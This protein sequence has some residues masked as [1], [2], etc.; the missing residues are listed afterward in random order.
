MRKLLYGLTLLALLIVIP[1]ATAQEISNVPSDLA[2]N[3]YYTVEDS[4]HFTLDDVITEYGCPVGIR[5]FNRALSLNAD[6][7][8]VAG[9]NLIIPSDS[10]LCAIDYAGT[11]EFITVYQAERER[12]GTNAYNLYIPLSEFAAEKNVCEAAI[13][14]LNPEWV[15]IWE[16]YNVGEGFYVDQATPSALPSYIRVPVDSPA[17]FETVEL[18]ATQRPRD[19]AV[20]LN[21]CEQVIWYFNTESIYAP[22][23][24][25]RSIYIPLD[26]QPCY[27]DGQILEYLG[28]PNQW[29]NYIP[30]EAVVLEKA[31][32]VYDFAIENGYCA[33]DLAGLNRHERFEPLQ[34]G[35]VVYVTEGVR[36]CEFVQELSVTT[37]TLAQ[38][39]NVCI[40]SLIAL[41]G[42][43]TSW[44]YVADTRVNLGSGSANPDAF[45]GGIFVPTEEAACYDE[46]GLRLG[47]NDRT[48]H[49]TSKDE[50]LFGIAQ[51]YGVCT[52]DLVK[53]NPLLANYPQSKL[54]SR[55]FIPEVPACSDVADD[56]FV[57]HQLK[58][59]DEAISYPA[60]QTLMSLSYLYNVCPS[61]IL[62]TNPSLVNQEREGFVS[63]WFYTY[64]H[65]HAV[66]SY[67]LNEMEA[68]QT[69]LIPTD[70]RPCYDYYLP[71]RGIG[72][73]QF[74]ASDEPL[75]IEYVCYSQ[76]VNPDTDYT[77]HEPVI[78]PVAYSDT[79]HCYNRMEDPRVVLNNETYTLYP[80]GMDAYL[81]ELAACF[82]ANGYE[83][84]RVEA[85][86]LGQ[87]RGDWYIDAYWGI[88]NAT[89]DCALIGDSYEAAMN[90]KREF[91]SQAGFGQINEEGLYAVTYGDTLTDIGR[92]YGY[93][94][95]W[96]KAEN[97]LTDEWVYPYQL[98]RLP[99]YPNL[100]QSGSV[101]GGILGLG[102]LGFGTKFALSLRHRRKG[103]RKNDE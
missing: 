30:A 7:T 22:S 90:W 97:N 45:F 72:H 96:I 11:I 38:E 92:R 34:A 6:S 59:R 95:E 81:F 49:E 62:E 63:S 66:R 18:G 58:P 17:C 78:S 80:F 64:D 43:L 9:Q 40:E 44:S 37:V 89:K 29:G 88:P 14:E 20:A 23:N 21:L 41:N 4:D 54:P 56:G 2:R 32:T 42:G 3:S 74:V 48:V 27:Q 83:I 36:R 69:I 101:V 52:A 85:T 86:D 25:A 87:A 1:L 8:I 67:M 26:R 51:E 53:A 82:G 33:S 73:Y 24:D 68:G 35:D 5:D 10:P 15:A 55:I 65:H 61:D 100:Y 57:H 19:I 31:S 75:P 91:Y 102:L 39:Y 16:T 79:A 77:G 28:Y 60:I 71:M 94:P 103:K 70:S 46:N 47:Q 50:W 93:L 84:I 12:N 13:R 98:L 99:S 76:E